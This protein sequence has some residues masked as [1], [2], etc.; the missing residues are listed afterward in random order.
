MAAVHESPV[1]TTAKPGGS[2][3]HESITI[4]LLG[5]QSREYLSL[6]A[7]LRI[8]GLCITGFSRV[9]DGRIEVTMVCASGTRRQ[10]REMAK[11]VCHSGSSFGA[12]WLVVPSSLSNLST[13][14]GSALLTAPGMS[15][16]TR[17]CPTNVDGPATPVRS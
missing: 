3:I 10:V 12:R 4:G 13:L 14:G 8:H 17:R 1:G 6:V 11:L 16:N 7:T 5:H 15:P 9:S 2:T